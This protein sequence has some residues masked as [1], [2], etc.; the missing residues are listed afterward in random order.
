MPGQVPKAVVQERYERLVALQDDVSWAENRAQVGRRL[1]LMVAEG[2]GARTA[3]PH[4]SAA[5]PR[6]TDWCTSPLRPCVVVR[7]GDVVEVESR[8][9]RRTTS[10]ATPRCWPSGP[11]ARATHGSPHPRSGNSAAVALGMP[12]IGAPPPPRDDLASSC[13]AGVPPRATIRELCSAPL[14]PP[15]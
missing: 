8:T 9:R 13:T 7:P 6:T 2:R 12:T 14:S 1:E 5:A 11:P 4:G 3:P 10:S 15:R